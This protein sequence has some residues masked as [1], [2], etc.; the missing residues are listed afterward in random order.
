[1]VPESRARARALPA[2]RARIVP[3]VSD[4]ATTPGAGDP[5][6]P[7]AAPVAPPPTDGGHRRLAWSTAIFSLA[8]G[9]SRVLGL[10]R[11]VVAKNYFGVRGPINAFEIAFL[12]PNT[13]RALVADAAL[14]SAFVPVFSDL[15]EK[16]ERKR[17]WRVASS[18]F[19]LTLL[20]L[21]AVTAF[22]M[23]VAPWLMRPLYPH[24]HALL[25]GLSRVLFPI[26]ALLGLSGVVVGILNTYDEFS[27]PALTPVAWNLAI[28][29]GLV[30]GVPYAHTTDGKLYVYAAAILVGTVILS[31]IATFLGLI[32]LVIPGLAMAIWFQFVGQVVILENRSY[33]DALRRCRALVRGVW[34]RTFAWVVVI[35]IASGL[36]GL[37]LSTVVAGALQPQDASERSRLVVAL[38]AN[39]P[40]SIL[41]L[42]FSTIALTLVYLHL[43]DRR[44]PE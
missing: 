1:M 19:W 22:F 10:V 31:A 44:P 7:A 3:R 9:L 23:L 13:V 27:I 15:I 39:I 38:A 32:A 42:P 34:W 25:V 41:V 36:V 24:D 35:N 8:T 29:I 14:S 33:L 6:D 2:A 28:I 11:E 17:A 26:V 16:G 40:S 4:G 20:G 18:L 30:V 43:R 12:V 37:L 5:A 21:G